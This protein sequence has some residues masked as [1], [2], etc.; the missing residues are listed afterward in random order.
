MLL[1]SSLV[2]RNIELYGE[3]LTLSKTTDTFKS[4]GLYIT[5]MFTDYSVHLTEGGNYHEEEL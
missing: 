5:R 3:N 2:L 1:S 4:D